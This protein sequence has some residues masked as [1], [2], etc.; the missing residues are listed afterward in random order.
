MCVAL[1]MIMHPGIVETFSLKT[2]NV[3]F[4]E[5]WEE[6]NCQSQRDSSSGE[7]ECPIFMG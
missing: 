2:Q 6:K 7:Q 3:D 4:R 5:A 1:L